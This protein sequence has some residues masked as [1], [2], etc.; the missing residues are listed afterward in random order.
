MNTLDLA[1]ISNNRKE[2]V[3]AEFRCAIVKA[4]LALLD[5]EAAALALKAGLVSPEQAVAMFWDSQAVQFLGLDL[6]AEAAPATARAYEEA[7]M[8][9]AQEV[10]A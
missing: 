3:L 10:L 4:R 2:Y 6:E 8:P 7:G 9:P 1:A 5:L